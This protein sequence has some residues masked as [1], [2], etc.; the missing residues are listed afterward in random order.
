VRSLYN[1]LQDSRLNHRCE[2]IAGIKG[3]ECSQQLTGFFKK[4]RQDHKNK[5]QAEIKK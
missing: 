3:K 1:I 5:P 2:V 4:L